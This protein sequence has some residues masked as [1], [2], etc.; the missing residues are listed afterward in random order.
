MQ[1][2]DKISKLKNIVLYIFIMDKFL[3]QPAV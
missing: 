1:I 3:F 2:Y